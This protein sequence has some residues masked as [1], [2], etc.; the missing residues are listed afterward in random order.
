MENISFILPSFNALDYLKWA[1]QSIR[2]NLSHEHEIIIVD[3]GSKKESIDW[4]KSIA[5]KDLNLKYKTHETNIGISYTYNEASMMATNEIVCLL[6][7]DMY[8]PKDFDKHM[9]NGL[10]KYDVVSPGRIEPPLYPATPDKVIRNFGILPS[11]FKPEAFNKFISTIPTKEMPD[12][13]FFPW[14]TTKTIIKAVGGLDTLYL[15]Y[16]VDDM[17]F[18]Y[19]LQLSGYKLG[20]TFDTFVYHIP[21]QSS[22]HNKDGNAT[23]E[24][25]RAQHLKSTRNFIRKFHL[26]Q[27]YVTDLKTMGFR[28]DLIRPNIQTNL[29]DENISKDVGQELIPLIEVFSDVVYMHP[30]YKESVTQYL[31][32]EKNMTIF[33][34][35]NKFK[36]VTELPEQSEDVSITITDDNIDSSLL[37]EYYDHLIVR[38]SEIGE[39]KL[40]GL[41]DQPFPFVQIKI[42]KDVALNN[43]K[44][45]LYSMR[46]N[47]GD[48]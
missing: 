22:K 12:V 36:F 26:S 23:P 1:Y 27:M 28:T 33:D 25:W 24:K 11:H 47:I 40:S 13:L 45:Y 38:L 46:T 14:M 30:K 37:L 8:I 44:L 39:D 32:I 17:D 4:I 20:T 18:Y 21:S 42:K 9:L 31:F 41:I 43:N 48:E 19:R 2:D 7:S 16:M 6:H 3:D 5:K 29:I 35:Q 34:I 10:K 15:K